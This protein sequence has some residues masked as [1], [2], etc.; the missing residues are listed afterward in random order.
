MEVK[1]MAGTAKSTVSKP[2]AD[3]KTPQKGAAAP[4]AK[5]KKK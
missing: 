2:A 5:P 1:Y 4:A 3:S